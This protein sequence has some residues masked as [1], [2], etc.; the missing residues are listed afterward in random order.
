MTRDDLK[1]RTKTFAVR[2]IR[3]SDALNQKRSAD[4]LAKQLIRSAS[5]VGAN[6]RSACRGRSEAEFVAKLGV[7]IE[8]ADEA[9]YWLEL[10]SE[11]ELIAPTRTQDLHQEA[12]ELVAIFTSAVKTTKQRISVSK[13]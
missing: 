5:S 7:V 1:R 4:V 6:Y 3:L 11:A 12:S 9:Q 13:S 2:C 10:I 8:E